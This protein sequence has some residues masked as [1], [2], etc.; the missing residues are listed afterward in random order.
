MLRVVFFCRITLAV[1]VIFALS[2]TAVADGLDPS[3]LAGIDQAEQRFG[4]QFSELYE[5][6]RAKGI[7]IDYQTVAKTMLEQFIPLARKDFQDGL[8]WR[9]KLAA[10]D[11]HAALDQ[12]IAEMQAYLK[13]PA[14]APKAK[15]FVTGHVE[16]DGS[17]FIGDRIDSEGNLSRGPVFLYGYGAFGQAQDDIPRWPGYGVNLIQSEQ[18]P[19]GVVMSEDEISLEPIERL[20]Q[21]MDRAA[22]HNVRVDVLLSPHY[23]PPWAGQK[24][25][26]LQTGGL[27][28]LDTPEGREVSARYLR[29]VIPLLK[30]KPALNSFCLSNEPNFIEMADAYNTKSMWGEYLKTV[31]PSVNKLNHRYG[32]S[33]SAFE[34]VPIPDN[35]AYQQPE[36]YDYCIFKHKRMAAW[37]KWMADVIHEMAP[38]VPV[39]VKLLVH[40]SGLLNRYTVCWGG[41]NERFVEISDINGNDCVFE[42]PYNGSRGGWAVPWQWQNIGYDLQRSLAW[43]PIFNSENH[44]THANRTGYVPPEHFRTA[45]W[46]GAIHGQGA[47]AVWCWERV[48]PDSSVKDA[49]YCNVMDRPRCAQAVGTTSLD[50]NRFAEEVTS[51]QSAASPVAIVYSMASII[52]NEHY[53]GSVGAVYEVLNFCGMR[54]SFISEKQLAAGKGPEYRMLVLPDATHVLPETFKAIKKLPRS[55]KLVIVGD[56]PQKDPYGKAYPARDVTRLRKMAMTLDRSAN[57][58]DDLWSKLYLALDRLGTLPS[59]RVVDAAT[60]EPVWGVEWVTSRL[61]G[62]ELVNMVN[63]TP[64]PVEVKLLRDGLAVEARN[65]LSLGGRDPVRRLAPMVPV[66]AELADAP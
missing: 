9:A 26:Q 23:F 22:E 31:H 50:L 30:D 63:L 57:P 48:A 44:L 15:R 10:Q 36:F 53:N 13:D 7:P 51:L 47:T 52:R 21:A 28:R 35:T 29:T 38:D 45:L 61:D 4:G 20:A 49:L 8:E 33:Y 54:V 16:I 12:A 65:L 19:A 17:S 58:K 32:T 2:V 39:H 42:A 18:G 66:L 25:P 14:L 55:V 46:Q 5:K 1:M 56:A 43:Q 27:A 59:V 41:D 11:F 62:R 34:Q 3:I 64:N 37:H 40:G 24:W 6:C 60:G